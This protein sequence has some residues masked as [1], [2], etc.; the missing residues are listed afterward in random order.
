MRVCGDET[1]K[2]ATRGRDIIGVAHGCKSACPVCN[3]AVSNAGIDAQLIAARDALLDREYLQTSGFATAMSRFVLQ[4]TVWTCN[5]MMQ[6]I[7]RAHP[8]LIN[9][10]EEYDAAGN[11][12]FCLSPFELLGRAEKYEIQALYYH[13]PQR[14]CDWF[15]EARGRLFVLHH[16]TG[17]YHEF[18]S[19]T[20]HQKYWNVLV[21]SDNA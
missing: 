18:K 12:A 13:P 21:C 3:P 17:F 5:A 7:R 11:A 14:L 16:K 6:F 10:I 15:V 9:E 1:F 2:S 4:R 8:S 19:L 20:I